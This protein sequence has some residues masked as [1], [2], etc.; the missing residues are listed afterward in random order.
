MKFVDESCEE[1]T[2]DS[3]INFCSTCTKEY[4]LENITYIAN[5]GSDL[6]KT[7]FLLVCWK[8]T[9]LEI[10]KY[11]IEDLKMDVNHMDKNKNNCLTLACRGNTNLEIIKYLIENLKMNINH[12]TKYGNN[13]LTLACRENTNLEI[14]RYLIDNQKMNVN[15]MDNYGNNCLTLA[16]WKNTNLEIIRYLIENQK[17]NINH[18]N[19]NKNNC[20]TLACWNNTNLEIIRYLIEN[21]KM[22]I[23]QMDKN[24]DNCLT[25]ACRKNTNLE[26]IRYLIDN[27]KMNINHVNKNR[28]NCLTL[29]CWKN[30]N[31]E[32]TRYLIEC[33]DAKISLNKISCDKWEKLMQYVTT[34]KNWHKFDKIFTNG[35]ERYDVYEIGEIVK[36]M[37]PILM[38][39][40]THLY[41]TYN[42]CDPF[43][44]KYIWKDFIKHVDDLKF[45]VPMT[46]IKKIEGIKRNERIFEHDF[47]KNDNLLLF[48]YNKKAYYGHREIV[49]DSIACLKEIKENADFNDPIELS[50]AMPEYL[51]NMWIGSMYTGKIEMNKIKPGDMMSFLKHV[52]QYPTDCLSIDTM[53]QSLVEYY[54]AIEQKCDIFNDPYLRDICHK[55]K[56]KKLYLCIHNNSVDL[57]NDKQYSNNFNNSIY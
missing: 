18:V 43:D 37:N 29:A 5:I 1:K 54:D 24:R 27:Q 21:Q 45:S 53:E 26:I 46:S 35:I 8:N 33:T 7:C 32:I 55:Y 23:N 49:Y 41:S 48:M 20:L 2:K 22:D 10:I 14:I 15:H 3:L 6:L 52:D 25:L 34:T 39:S 19:E 16:C 38:I 31:L 57:L 36:K 40:Q 42:V 28:D 11:L 50:G 51:I 47:A 56:L 44:E 12:T 30:T 9:N 13:C 17:M 4:F